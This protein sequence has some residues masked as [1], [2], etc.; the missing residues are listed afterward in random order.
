MKIHKFNV[1]LGIVFIFLKS[2]FLNVVNVAFLHEN[3]DHSTIVRPRF[4]DE[5]KWIFSDA[6]EDFD[7]K[8]TNYTDY[9]IVTILINKIF[10]VYLSNSIFIWQFYKTCKDHNIVSVLSS[11]FGKETGWLMNSQFIK[12]NRTGVDTDL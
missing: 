9:S 11:V 4:T 8:T 1:F 5:L 7:V 12:D 3:Y 6:P 10:Y 2:F